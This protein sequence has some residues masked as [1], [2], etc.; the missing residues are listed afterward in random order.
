MHF[1]KSKDDTVTSFKRNP[2]PVEQHLSFSRAFQLFASICCK[3]FSSG[4]SAMFQY[5]T[6]IQTLAPPKRQSWLL[7][8]KK[9]RTLRAKQHLPWDRLHVETHLYTSLSNSPQSS[10]PNSN[11]PV[12][13]HLFFVEGTVGNMKEPENAVNSIAHNSISV[14]TATESTWVPS[15]ESPQTNPTPQQLG[16]R[17]K[18]PPCNLTA[19]LQQLMYKT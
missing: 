9:F 5:M 4:A 8:D 10:K 15:V 18:T 14:Q 13:K 17:P 3:T 16:A 1:K 11:T 2:A 7:Y 6:I 19:R 12:P